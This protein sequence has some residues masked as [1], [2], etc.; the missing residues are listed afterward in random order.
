MIKSAIQKKEEEKNADNAPALKMKKQVC[1]FIPS[2]SCCFGQVDKLA[3]RHDIAHKIKEL[4]EK[5]D[6]ITKERER[7]GFEIT[8]YPAPRVVE[9]P[10]TTSLVDESEICGLDTVKK[11][12]VGKLLGNGSEEERGPRLISLVG[13]GGIGKT[14]LAQLAYNDPEVQAYFKIKVWVCV[15]DPFDQCKV[16]KAILDSIKGQSSDMTELQ[17]LLNRICDEVRGKK[18]LLVCDDVWKEDSTAW[19]PFRIALKCVAQGSRIIVTTRKRRV[20][21]IMESVSMIDLK[22]LSKEDCWLVFSKRAFFSRDP[23][24]CEQLEDLGRQKIGRASCRERV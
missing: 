2:P 15:S 4:N 17:I 7:Y 23:R 11:N 6:D 8:N 18:F 14:T 16:A 20:A 21:E 19:E 1:S 22:E 9:R 10:Q 12:L 13:M 5:L 3:R 24:Q